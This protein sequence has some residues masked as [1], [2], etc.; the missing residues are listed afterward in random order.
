[1]PQL[2]SREKSDK[3]GRWEERECRFYP[4]DFGTKGWKR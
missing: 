3:N 2:F 1:M 4:L